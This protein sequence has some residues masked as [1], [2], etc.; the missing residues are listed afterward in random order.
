MLNPKNIGPGEE[1]H[2]LF[3]N[4]RVN[5]YYSSYNYRDHDGELFS[6]VKLSLDKC[7]A[8]RDAW[9]ERRKA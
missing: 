1:Q 5:E 2:E 6:C 7:R 9:L 4:K 8:A 3:L